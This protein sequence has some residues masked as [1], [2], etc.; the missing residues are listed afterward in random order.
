MAADED[1][2]PGDGN[3]HP[4]PRHQNDNK[5]QPFFEDLQDLQDIEQANVD[6][7]EAQPIIGALAAAVT[8][9]FNASWPAGP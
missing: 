4:L 7:W 2:I 6:E 8:T 3:P 9:K 5:H 1:P